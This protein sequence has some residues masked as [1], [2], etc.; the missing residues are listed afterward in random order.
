MKLRDIAL[1]SC[2]PALW[3]VSYAL[4]KP[5]TVHFPPIF[6]MFLVYGASGLA[7]FRPGRRVHASRWILFAIAAFGGAIQSSLIFAGIAGLP[8]STA[9][10]VVQAQVPSAVLAAW[11]IGKE[12]PSARRVVGI[13]ISGTGIAV[14][15]G[16]PE[17]VDNL[18]SLILVLLGTLSWGISQ[19]LARRFG[20]DS[21]QSMTAAIMLYSTPQLLLASLILE[22]GQIQ[23]ALTASASDW[24]AVGILAIGGFVVAY[25]I[26][27]GLLQRH[28][29]DQIA[30]FALLMPLIG[31]LTS[32]GFLGETLTRS[33]LIG[34]A[35]IVAGIAIIVI[36][37]RLRRYAARTGE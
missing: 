7:L 30:P 14:I 24:V 23:A 35:I 6:M 12:R 4:A 15:A 22:D 19:G 18:V 8:A 34:G 37:P 1:A 29:V 5:A 3:G 16:A 17:G 11:I 13:L 2:P 26:W 20:R 28:R 31:V 36:D 21:G 32:I 9:I 27:Y 10:L 33:S 25:S